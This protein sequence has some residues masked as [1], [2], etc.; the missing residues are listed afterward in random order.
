MS[1]FVYTRGFPLAFTK[2][3]ISEVFRPYG[4]LKK[5]EITS[6]DHK[7]YAIVRYY[8]IE[9]AERAIKAIHGADINGVIWYAAIPE[10]PS[11]WK[12]YRQRNDRIFKERKKTLY[13]RDFPDTFTHGEAMKIFS[14]YGKILSI[15]VKFPKAFITFDD[16]ISANKAVNGESWLVFEG[17][18]VFVNMLKEKRSL[19]AY[20]QNKKYRKIDYNQRVRTN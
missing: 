18:R 17:K 4:K 10:T 19:G 12:A 13:L 5:I 20:I 8:N 16:R 15:S 6:E 3:D 1:K 7:L 14:K 2:S 11:N 9:N